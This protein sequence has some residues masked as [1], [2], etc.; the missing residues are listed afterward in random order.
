MNVEVEGSGYV[1]MTEDDADGLVVAVAF[2]AACGETMSKSVEFQRRYAKLLHKLHVIVAVG[3]RLNGVRLVAYDVVVA[4]NHLFQ[5]SY[6]RH[7]GFV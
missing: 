4:V 5:W 7:K 2:Y 3:T 1:S 6:H